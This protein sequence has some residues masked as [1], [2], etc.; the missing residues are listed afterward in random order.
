MVYHLVRMVPVEVD[1]LVK[2]VP[3]AV[4]CLL[5]VFPVEV[6]LL[7]GVVP[8]SFQERQGKMM[9]MRKQDES[10]NGSPKMW[11]ILMFIII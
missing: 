4:H 3:V 6:D 9:I 5:G 10:M 1:L 11:I 2:M 8:D 7:V